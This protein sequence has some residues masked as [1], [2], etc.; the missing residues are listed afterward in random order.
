MPHTIAISESGNVE[1]ISVTRARHT[2]LREIK[3]IQPYT[4][5]FGFLLVTLKR[6]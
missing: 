1:F 5:Q 6:Y 3:S 2:T 4:A